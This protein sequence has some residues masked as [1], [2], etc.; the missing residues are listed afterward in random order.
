M[1]LAAGNVK[2]VSLELGGKSPNIVFA[3][4]DLEKFAAQSPFAIFD[5][6]GQDCTAR[7]R[8]LVDRRVH[9]R[10]VEL[11]VEATRKIVV[12]DPAD[13]KTQV[14][15]LVH[16]KQRERVLGYVEAGREEGAELLSA[17]RRRQAQCSTRGPS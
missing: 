2:K 15:S 5:N 9:D 4:A 14:G 6:A 13:E 17:A 12:G 7:S 1:R 16:E 11:F 8:I 3:D 10:V